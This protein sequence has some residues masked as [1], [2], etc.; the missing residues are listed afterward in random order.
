MFLFN[1][2]I[3]EQQFTSEIQIANVALLYKKGSPEDGINYRQI[4]LTCSL[5]N[6][7]ESLLADQLNDYSNKKGC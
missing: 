3:N 4:S 5:S 2:I 1:A 7:F 6:K